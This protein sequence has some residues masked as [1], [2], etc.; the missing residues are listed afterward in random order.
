MKL[1]LQLKYTTYFL[2]I[3]G[4]KINRAQPF[5]MVTETKCKAK[6]VMETRIVCRYG[7]G[8]TVYRTQNFISREILRGWDNLKIENVGRDIQ[9][10]LGE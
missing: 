8:T 3:V 6:C 10:L 5:A 7:C 2:R 1:T 4:C 9:L